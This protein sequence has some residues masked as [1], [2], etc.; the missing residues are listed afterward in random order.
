L[1]HV[2]PTVVYG[3]ATLSAGVEVGEVDAGGDVVVGGDA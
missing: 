1:L 2:E 3:D